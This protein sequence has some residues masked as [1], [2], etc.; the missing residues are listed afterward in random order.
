VCAGGFRL[1]GE[2]DVLISF[3]QLKGPGQRIP[4]RK[5]QL[6]GHAHPV[7]IEIKNHRISNLSNLL[8]SFTSQSW[9]SR[10]SPLCAR[11]LLQGLRVRQ[12]GA[13]T[14]RV[15]AC[16]CMLMMLLGKIT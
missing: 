16:K 1:L 10:S 9:S 13:K 8:S 14:L 15:A 5:L 4:F 7:L 11:L 6:I 12:L 2:D 3:A